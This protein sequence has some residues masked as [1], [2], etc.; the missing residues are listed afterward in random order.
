MDN[1]ELI[2]LLK[3]IGKR[4]ENE[5][6]EISNYIDE[7]IVLKIKD[8]RTI[9]YVF[10]SILSILFIDDD[11]KRMVFHKL[12]NYCRTF[13]KELADDYDEMLE[14]DLTDDE[15]LNDTICK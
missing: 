13:N 12:S 3:E 1:D 10:D 9:S 6:E 2:D 11:K 7:I 8:E 15:E 14:K 5:I 4:S